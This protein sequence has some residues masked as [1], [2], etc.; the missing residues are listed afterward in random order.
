MCFVP[1]EGLYH[2]WQ[3]PSGSRVYSGQFCREARAGCAGHATCNMQHAT[4][5]QYPT[6]QR[7][8][9]RNFLDV[10]VFGCLKRTS[11]PEDLEVVELVEVLGS[12]GAPGRAAGRVSGSSCIAA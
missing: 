3:E 7:I 12:G 9:C 8:C 11:A 1:G 5:N 10:A 2:F 6:S 4:A